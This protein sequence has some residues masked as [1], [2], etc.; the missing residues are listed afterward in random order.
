MI[1]RTLLTRMLLSSIIGIITI[2]SQ[3]TF[4]AD[5]IELY[6]TN[7]KISVP[8]GESIEYS[9]DVINNSELKKNCNLAFLFNLLCCAD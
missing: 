7:T 4:A 6:T 1:T 8:P 9:I 2:F 3:N 5:Q